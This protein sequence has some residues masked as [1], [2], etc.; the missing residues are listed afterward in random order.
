[1]RILSTIEILGNE[2]ILYTENEMDYFSASEVGEMIGYSKANTSKMVAKIDED[3]KIK[4]CIDKKSLGFKNGNVSYSH[5][6]P[7]NREQWF[8]NKDGLYELLF[9][10][11]NEKS[12]KFK[13][14]VKRI[15]KEIE[16]NKFY[17]ATEKDDKWIGV[18]NDT[19]VI[20]KEETDTIK[21]FV[22]LAKQQGS[23]K[24][25]W[26]YKHF[27]NL[28]RNK[29]KIPKELKRDEL[30]QKTLRD[31]QALET[32]VTMK[33]SNLILTDTHYKEI[34]EIIKKMIMD[35]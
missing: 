5:N 23:T 27:T 1:M 34:Y 26:Y 18:R 7:R 22:E 2:L 25:N 33:L 32:I 29:L 31:I 4:C 8:L 11:K 35:I 13:K 10:G 12:V 3:E 15:L 16:R 21:E 9:L 17:I 24:P 30:S 14:E 28:V 6:D 19:K 20:R